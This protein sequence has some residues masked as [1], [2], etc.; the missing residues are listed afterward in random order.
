MSDK[1]ET[2]IDDPTV[3]TINVEDDA[4]DK[5]HGPKVVSDKAQTIPPAARLPIKGTTK[6]VQKGKRPIPKVKASFS[7]LSRDRPQQLIGVQV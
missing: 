5:V 3:V 1:T 2:K 6:Q 7:I 4:T